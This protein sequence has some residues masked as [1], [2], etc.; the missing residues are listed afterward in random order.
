MRATR[1]QDW[2]AL[3]HKIA[4]QHRDRLEDARHDGQAYLRRGAGGPGHHFTWLDPAIPGDASVNIRWYIEQVRLAEQAKFDLVFIVD[5]QFITP[6]SPHHYLS[7]LEPLTLL[8]AVAV[9]TTHIGLVGT[10]TTSYNEP[11]NVARRL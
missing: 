5:S 3:L 11:F 4:A 10:I 9:H 7:R 8:S 2:K 1:V 6:D